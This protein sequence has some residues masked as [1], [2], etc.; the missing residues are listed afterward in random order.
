MFY[1]VYI[2]KSLN[3]DKLYVGYTN[4]LKRRIIEHDRGENFS[5]KMRKPF[6]LIY[7]EAYRDKRDAE[8]RE[9]FF[10]T[11]WGRQYINKTLKNFL[12]EKLRR[13]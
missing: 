3:D 4:D 13:E 6:E 8:N 9:R 10:K 12:I 11:G 5:T 2:L 1:Y 7:Y